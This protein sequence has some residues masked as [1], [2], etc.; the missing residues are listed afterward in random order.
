MMQCDEGYEGHVSEVGV[1]DT[2]E[3]SSRSLYLT[4]SFVHRP[5]QALWTQKTIKPLSMF[6]FSYT[7]GTLTTRSAHFENV[8][9]DGT[10]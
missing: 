9:G 7:L 2:P 3:S 1:Y 8:L 6:F 10:L 4:L 5:L